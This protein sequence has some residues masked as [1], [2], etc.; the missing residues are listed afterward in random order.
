MILFYLYQHNVAGQATAKLFFEVDHST[1][2]CELHRVMQTCPP[3]HDKLLPSSRK[4]H[5]CENRFH[6]FLN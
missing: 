1:I 2:G 6:S 5:Y 3:G 4:T